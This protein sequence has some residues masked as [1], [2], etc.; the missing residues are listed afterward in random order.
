MSGVRYVGWSAETAPR[1]TGRKG[2]HVLPKSI[3][4]QAQD[5]G[6]TT[7]RIVSVKAMLTMLARQSGSQMV[8]ESPLPVIHKG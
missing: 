3:Q 1:A 6:R 4:E 2:I 8:L 5:E 7:S